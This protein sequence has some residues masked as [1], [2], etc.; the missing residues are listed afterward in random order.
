MASTRRLAWAFAALTTVTYVLVVFG[1][2]VRLKGAGLSCPDWP[3]CYGELVPSMSFGVVFEVG[4]RYLASA[5]SLGLVGLTIWTCFLPKARKLLGRWLIA[6][7]GILGVQI[8]LGGL[9]VLQLLA[10]WTV[11]SHLLCGNAFALILALIT[12]RLFAMD[13]AP[14]LG[15]LPAA[16]RILVPLSAV[17]LVVQMSLGGLVAATFAGQACVEWP[18]CVGSDWFPTLS[19][20]VGLHIFHRLTAYALAFAVWAL[21]AVC[22]KSPVLGRITKVAAVLVFV[23]VALGVSN[24]LLHLPS[25][26]SA[27]HSLGAALLC[28]VIGLIVDRS[29]RP[30]AVDSAPLELKDAA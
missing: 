5:V 7:F 25:E 26:V 21:A 27:A 16:A 10:S 4:H 18:A 13:R 8:V 12:A 1:A 30:L 6:A 29:F 11:T 17:L 9:T 22:W 14:A 23:Q 24:V 28:L 15:T 20:P 3:L 19:G 2:V